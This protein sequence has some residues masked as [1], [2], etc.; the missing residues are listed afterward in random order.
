MFSQFLSRANIRYWGQP[1][2]NN[3][4][5]EI[6]ADPNSLVINYEKK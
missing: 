1:P 6:V 2:L 5:N 4:K 3:Y